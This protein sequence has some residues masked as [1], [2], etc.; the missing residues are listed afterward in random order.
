MNGNPPLGILLGV[1][2]VVAVAGLVSGVQDFLRSFGLIE[3]TVL[4]EV[5]AEPSCQPT[6]DFLGIAR[7]LLV[8][9]DFMGVSPLWV[10]E[11]D[12]L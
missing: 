9:D 2:E 12:L 10:G 8:G 7:R 3:V 11:Q 6:K 4:L 5:P 1:W